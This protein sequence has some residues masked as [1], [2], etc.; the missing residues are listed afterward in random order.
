MKELALP[1]NKAYAAK[2]KT[3][4]A[5]AEPIRKELEK[6]NRI[7]TLPFGE[8]VMR[9]LRQFSQPSKATHDVICAYLLLLGQSEGYTR[10]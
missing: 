1:K 3:E 8:S 7:K 10:V 6:Q 4:L 2:L 9:S 5:R